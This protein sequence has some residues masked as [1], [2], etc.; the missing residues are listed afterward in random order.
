MLPPERANRLAYLAIGLAVAAALFLTTYY[1]IVPTH[2]VGGEEG[3]SYLTTVSDSVIPNSS[4]YLFVYG[5]SGCKAC[6]PFKKFLSENYGGIMIFCDLAT[7]SSCRLRFFDLIS[8]NEVPPE[9]PMTFVVSKEGIVAIV[10]G[11]VED[12]S[13]WD[14]LISSKPTSSTSIPIYG[15]SYRVIKYLK[16]ENQTEFISKYLP[17]VARLTS[18]KPS[19]TP[20]LPLGGPE[21]LATVATLALLDSI[22]PCCIYIYAT[23]LIA[24][25]TY[26]LRTL[27]NSRRALLVSGVPFIASVYVGYYLLGLGLTRAFAYVPL[28]VFGIAAIA[29]GAWIILTSGGSE[30]VLGKEKLLKLIPKAKTSALIS[31]VLGFCVTYAI[32]PCSAG[33]YVVFTG[34]ISRVGLT[35]AL[36][37]L[38]LYNVIFITPLVAILAISLKLTEVDKVRDFI[39]KYNKL[40]SV[41]MGIVLVILGVYVTLA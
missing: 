41:A 25:A 2:A 11:D 27:A 20:P 29:F 37:W 12:K 21:L 39:I 8:T 34:L 5:S 13:F 26:G 16:V 1:A 40:I 6:I 22:N 10:V 24:A 35:S 18:I 36:A 17:E 30:R 19:A 9:I 28:K 38:A 3:T 32:L 15:G 23:L 31:A 4:V 14:K 7:N 33:P